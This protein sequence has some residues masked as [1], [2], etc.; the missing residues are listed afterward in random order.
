MRRAD[1]TFESGGARCAAW[2]YRPGASGTVPCVV[3]APGFSSVREQRLDAYA[4]RFA[5]AG[6]AA[7][8]FDYRHFGASEGEPRQLV[9]IKLQ[10][11][12]W[13]GA[14]SAAREQDDI[15]PDRVALFGVSL[16]GG[17]V[18]ELA[19][20]DPR[21]AAVISQSPFVDGR[22]TLRLL[23]TANVLRLSAAGLRD[24]VGAW[25]NRPP[26]LI[27]AVGD[28]G[29]LAAM[30]TPDATAGMATITPAGST[31]R[32]EVAA[33]IALRIGAYR[34]GRRASE[35]TC[36]VLVCVC[37]NETLAPPKA[38][39]EVADAIPRGEARRYATGHFEICLGEWFERIVADQTEFLTRSLLIGSREG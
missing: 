7:L 31:W 23:G 8:L 29:D 25:L 12:D 21:V 13:R 26:Y 39:L 24:Q 27:K 20:E 11:E 3:L 2:L 18:L 14:I 33:R 9:D 17:Y 30:A 32:N 5:R 38:A 19:A 22:A 10:L 34:P 36:P 16:S 6:L 1:V 28:P 37:E 35:V 15:D 4:E